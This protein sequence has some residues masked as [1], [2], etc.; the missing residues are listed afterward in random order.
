MR[1]KITPT[2]KVRMTTGKRAT[3]LPSRI[4]VCSPSPAGTVQFFVDCK[5]LEAQLMLQLIS[6][7][8]TSWAGPNDDGIEMRVIT[9]SHTV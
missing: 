2:V 8:N 5:I 7:G 4:G 6:H 1:R 9:D 3:S